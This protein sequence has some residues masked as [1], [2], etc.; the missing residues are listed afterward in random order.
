MT[1]THWL[2]LAGVVPACGVP[3]ATATALV[4]AVL[5]HPKP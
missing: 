1:F 3:P 4:L 5:R 2:L